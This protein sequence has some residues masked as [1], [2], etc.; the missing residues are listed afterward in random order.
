MELHCDRGVQKRLAVAERHALPM[1][2]VNRPAKSAQ[3]LSRPITCQ[4]RLLGAIYCTFKQY[5]MVCVSCANNTKSK[6]V[7]CEVFYSMILL[8]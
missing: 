4:K 7:D 3:S 1:G 8:Y 2:R 5:F 6:R